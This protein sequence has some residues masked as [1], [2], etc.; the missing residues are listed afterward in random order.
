ML[1]QPQFEISGTAANIAFVLL[2]LENIAH[3]HL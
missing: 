3:Q 2:G 1:G